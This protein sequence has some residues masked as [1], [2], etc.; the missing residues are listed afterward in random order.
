MV[1][2]NL[3]ASA[4]DEQHEE[5]VQ[6]VL[7]LQPPRKSRIDRRRSLRNAGMLPDEC[8]YAGKFA[9]ALSQGDQAEQRCGGD[10]QAPQRVDPAPSNADPRRDAVLRRHPVIEADAIVGIAKFRAEPLDR[11]RF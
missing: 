8:F 5:H 1:R 11:E 4:H 9:Q 7:K 10:R 2:Q 3:Q 6:E